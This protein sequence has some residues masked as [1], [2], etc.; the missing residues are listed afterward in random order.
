MNSIQFISSQVD[1]LITASTPSRR[2][3]LST[4]SAYNTPHEEPPRTRPCLSI[5]EDDEEKQP[6]HTRPAE[7]EH[8]LLRV[9]LFLPRLLW[10]LIYTPLAWTYTLIFH[11]TPPHK[12]ANDDQHRLES[13]VRNAYKSIFAAFTSAFWSDTGLDFEPPNIGT[14]K[15]PYV[16]PANFRTVKPPASTPQQ[17]QQQ[18]RG[19]RKVKP[20]L[21]YALRY[22]RALAPPRPLLPV[23]TRRNQCHSKT[24][25][26]DLDETLIHTLA[27]PTPLTQG[28]PV[29]VKLPVPA[30]G[31][32][33]A[34]KYFAALY[35]VLKRPGLD[36]FLETVSQ[37]YNLVIFTASVQAY[38]DPMIDLLEQDRPYF[39]RRLYRDSCTL[40]AHSPSRSSTT[41]GYVKDLSKVEPDL[42]NVLILDNSPTSYQNQETN[43]IGIEGWINDP[44]DTALMSLIPML[45]ALRYA[46][47]VRSVL[48]LKNGETMFM[49]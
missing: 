40:V 28:I 36:E 16:Q 12:D 6:N 34:T 23:H 4:A 9:S 37:W 3:S 24:L 1:S 27:R 10:T 21:S 15:S 35:T 48:G 8:L 41:D 18:R 13:S 26:L 32:S 5:D 14:V 19:T 38:A 42:A 2:G 31:S 25:V 46:T 17:Q 43:A 39:A 44:S 45:S 49:Q 29:E 7:R 33:G 20:P 30:S 47:D 22:P 11:S